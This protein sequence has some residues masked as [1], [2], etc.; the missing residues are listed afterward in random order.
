VTMMIFFVGGVSAAM[1]L[2]F[3]WWSGQTTDAIL[4]SMPSLVYV[5]GLSGAI[6]IVNYYRDAVREGGLDGAPETALRHGWFPCTLAACTTALGLLSLFIGSGV[7]PIKKFGAFGAIG[8]MATLILLFT[9]LPSALHVWNPGYHKRLKKDR[10][11]R[12]GI[13][14]ITTRFWTMA[15]AWVIRRHWW[16]T[17]GCVILFLVFAAGLPSVNTTV[18]LLKLFHPEAKIIRD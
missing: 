16:V 10:N 6:H 3:V 4:M 13:S 17:S 14:N 15:G 1:S 9:Y 8:V 18:N 12:G 11:R 5:L 7:I 2:A